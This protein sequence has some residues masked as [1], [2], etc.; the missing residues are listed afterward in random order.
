MSLPFLDRGD[1]GAR[2]N[3]DLGQ[4]ALQSHARS[5]SL[6]APPLTPAQL[7]DLCGEANEFARNRGGQPGQSAEFAVVWLGEPPLGAVARA[8]PFLDADADAAVALVCVS[9]DASAASASVWD[10]GTVA[11]TAAD[12][13][14]GR[15]HDF[16]SARRL[17]ELTFRPL[18]AAHSKTKEW[19]P[20]RAAA[21]VATA[22]RAWRRG[23]DVLAALD[24]LPRSDAFVVQRDQSAASADAAVADVLL[25]GNDGGAASRE[26]PPQRGDGGVAFNSQARMFF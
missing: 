21:V 15:I 1:G 3:R 2:I 16:L 11:A 17:N 5:R 6:R 26:P 25:R 12:G 19:A 24:Q 9:C 13:A 4:A 10:R 23:E 14:L 20:T 22:A 18:P 8:L 7:Y